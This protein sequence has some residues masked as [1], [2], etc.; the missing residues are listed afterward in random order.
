MEKINNLIG[1]DCLHGSPGLPVK[2]KV[3]AI[4]LNIV[5]EKATIHFESGGAT[6]MPIETLDKIADEWKDGYTEACYNPWKC[7]VTKRSGMLEQI[8]FH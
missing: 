1:Q 4:D 3:V 8:V 2:E 6:E 5:N 7:S